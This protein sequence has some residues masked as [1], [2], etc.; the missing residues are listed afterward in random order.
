MQKTV[1]A[2]LRNEWWTSWTTWYNIANE[3]M[4][5]QTFMLKNMNNLNGIQEK[6]I[7]KTGRIYQGRLLWLKWTIAK[8]R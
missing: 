6:K 5:K 7:G 4:E 8:E 3:S 1:A 2:Y